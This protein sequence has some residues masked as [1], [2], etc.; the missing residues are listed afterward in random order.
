MK[1]ECIENLNIKSDG[2]YVDATLGYAGHSSEILKKLTSGMLYAFDNDELAI[3][4]STKIL[5][6]ISNNF[7]I[8]P[9]SSFFLL[10]K[11][12]IALIIIS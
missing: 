1:K 9:T 11:L 4:E 6:E 5:G 12:T 2:I 3:E 8:L 7:K 10:I